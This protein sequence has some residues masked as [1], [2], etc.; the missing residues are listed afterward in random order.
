MKKRRKK[1]L[2]NNI[3][4]YFNKFLKKNSLTKFM[5][6]VKLEKVNINKYLILLF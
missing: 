1:S 3:I 2:M 6:L 4:N 5:I